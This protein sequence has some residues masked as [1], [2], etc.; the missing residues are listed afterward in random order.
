MTKNLC[1][2]VL[3]APAHSIVCSLGSGCDRPRQTARSLLAEAV[4]GEAQGERGPTWVSGSTT[5]LHAGEAALCGHTGPTSM[6]TFSVAC[7]WL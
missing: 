6:V 4:G 2:A 7:H 3:K 1:L 5:C